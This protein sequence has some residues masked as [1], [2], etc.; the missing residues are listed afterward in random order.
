LASCI[1]LILHLKVYQEIV[2]PKQLDWRHHNNKQV[3]K[4]QES[5]QEQIKSLLSIH[6]MIGWSGRENINIEAPQMS[7]RAHRYLALDQTYNS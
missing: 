5:R 3:G 7:F 1:S 6:R 2:T 4:I